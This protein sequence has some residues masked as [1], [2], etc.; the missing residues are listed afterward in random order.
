MVH[1]SY[2]V[3]QTK[4]KK[5]K[6]V[7]IM[8]TT[9]ELIKRYGLEVIRDGRICAHNGDLIKKD[10]ADGE[11]RARLDEVREYLKAEKEAAETARK[12]RQAKIDAIEGLKEL[13][14]AISDWNEYHYKFNK[15]LASEF[16]AR[17]PQKPES[18]IDELKAQYPRATAYLIAEGWTYSSNHEK[19]SIGKRALEKII[20][21]ENYEETI[22]KMKE[23]WSANCDK[24]MWD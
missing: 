15:C 3:R 18:D 13:Q 2:K 21:N 7:N 19:S 1:Y 11:I 6:E 9:E 4:Q 23:E 16:A 10:D 22:K 17:F 12:E 20:N 5:N 8:M 14:K 24:H